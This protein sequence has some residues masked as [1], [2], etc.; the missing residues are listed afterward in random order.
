MLQYSYATP[1]V[2]GGMG[3]LTG[4]L[5]GGVASDTVIDT[6]IK[7]SRRLWMARKSGLSKSLAKLLKAQRKAARKRFSKMLATEL[8]TELG[9]SLMLSL[10]ELGYKK[11]INY[12]VDQFK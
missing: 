9:G 2:G 3:A 7:A 11:V 1:V 10:P 8:A 12:Y 6:G 4:C 5:G